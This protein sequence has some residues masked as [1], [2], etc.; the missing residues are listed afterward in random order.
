[1]TV[2]D[3]ITAGLVEMKQAGE[4]NEYVHELLL[5]RIDSITAIIS[6]CGSLG[7]AV[8]SELYGLDMDPGYTA[9]GEVMTPVSREEALRLYDV[10][11]PIYR[12]Y[13]DDNEGL[14]ED[15]AD[16]ESGDSHYAVEH[17]QPQSLVQNM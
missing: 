17:D 11:T 8:K 16:I 7:E 6:D 4:I 14:C 13:P 5:T 15:R 1:M 2:K 9:Y 12:I 10:G 3:Q